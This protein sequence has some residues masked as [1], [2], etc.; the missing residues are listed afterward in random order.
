MI[1]MT[2]S[3]ALTVGTN[4]LPPHHNVICSPPCCRAFTP[5]TLD[6]SEARLSIHGKISDAST[7]AI[8]RNKPTLSDPTLSL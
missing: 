6:T 5:S 3:L 4:P 8:W 2:G 1:S 7:K